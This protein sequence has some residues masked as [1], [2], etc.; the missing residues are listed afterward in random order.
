[1]DDE[2][3]AKSKL[4]DALLNHRWGLPVALFVFLF[5]VLATDVYPVWVK[6][7]SETLARTASEEA[8]AAAEADRL[9]QELFR[10]QQQGVLELESF[11]RDVVRSYENRR[12]PVEAWVKYRDAFSGELMFVDVNLIYESKYGTVPRTYGLTMEEA[13]TDAIEFPTE[14]HR[15][16]W[17][18]WR[19]ND[20]RALRLGPGK[21]LA[22][23]EEAQLKTGE[24]IEK[25]YEKCAFKIGVE[26]FVLGYSLE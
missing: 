6:R 5:Y 16:M 19:L 12:N 17:A 3:R 22:F 25:W 21:C 4:V 10:L 18:R 13:Y 14:R 15:A 7:Q 26:E 11:W 20:Q 8:A 1:M 23:Q 9:Q 24:F 2:E